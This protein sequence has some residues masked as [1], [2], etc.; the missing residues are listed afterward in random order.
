MAGYLLTLSLLASTA[1]SDDFVAQK[2]NRGSLTGTSFGIPS[3][4]ATYDYVI[5]GGGTAGSVVASRLTQHTNATVAMIEAGNFYEMSNG[6]WSQIPYW[7][8]QW[9]GAA[10]DDWQPLI[11]WGLFT[12][13]QVNGKRIHY[14]QGKNLGGSTGRNQMMYHR[15]TVGSYDA[16]AEWVG[17]DAY[18][19]DNMLKYYQRSIKYIENAANRPANTTPPASP[20]AY[21][22]TGG[23]LIVSHAGYVHPLAKYGPAAFSSIG[24]KMIND[25]S[26][27]H[28]DGYSYWPFTIDPATG[29]RSSAETSFLGESLSRPKLTTYIN[30]HV[31]NIL[32]SKNGTAIGANVTNYG[33]RPFTLTARKEVIVS[34]GAYH[35]PQLLM[36]SGIGPKET[37]QKYNISVIKDAPGVGQNMW[38]SHNI[39]GPVYKINVTGYSTW[40]Q[41]GFAEQA[42]AQLL[43]NGSGPLTNTGL[44][45]GAW[46]KLPAA[47]RANLT[48]E[49]LEALSV[50]PSD[51]PE[52]EWSISSSSK[53]L[54][55]SD[56]TQ[57][58]GTIGA[59]LVA[60][61]SRGNMTIRSAS[62]MVPPVI[63]PN[64]LRDSTDQQVAIQ[65]YRRAREAWKA[66]PLKVGDEVSP[67][68]NVTSDADL[69]AAIK[70]A[71]GPIHHAS[72][73]CA[74]GTA[75]NPMAVVDSKAR[76]YGVHNLRVIDSSSFPFTPPGH[77][78]GVTYAHAEK[79]VD[80]VIEAWNASM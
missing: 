34:A 13:P 14:A 3:T 52:I 55:A 42:N 46:E 1:Y 24:L 49:A 11:D 18:K 50:F 76:V 38:D 12:E 39:G 23:P 56:A 7:S 48:P 29:L 44:D 66:I 17:D 15:P 33:M 60:A 41:P 62:N 6:N 65:A 53:T 63:N 32:F 36:V 80:D 67:G 70:K 40:Q 72:A 74:M 5:I 79:L 58:Y 4:N 21:S 45:M 57:Q 2:S 25:F 64:W 22:A 75:A 73:S 16:W 71:L 20:G 8:E 31:N 26:G 59:V 68:K 27:G 43:K 77:T 35:S 19:W 47:S 30:A 51:W 10:E 28:L 61:T 78:Q 54:T 69:L 37:L 9:V